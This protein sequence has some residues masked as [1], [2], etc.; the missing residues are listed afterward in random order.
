MTILALNKEKLIV[1]NFLHLT[2]G[3]SSIRTDYREY[4]IIHTFDWYIKHSKQQ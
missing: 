3:D 2:Q 4:S 1:D